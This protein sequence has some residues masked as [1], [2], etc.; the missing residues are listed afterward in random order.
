MVNTVVHE[1]EHSWWSPWDDTINPVPTQLGND[2][3]H[4]FQQEG[5]ANAPC[6]TKP[7]R[8]GDGNPGGHK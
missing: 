3:Q 4:L 8:N 2:A 5:E 1:W 7:D 6:W